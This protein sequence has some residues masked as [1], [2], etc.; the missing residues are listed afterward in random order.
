M[1]CF[2]P[3]SK[4][5]NTFTISGEELKHLKV[6]RIKPG[7]KVG[8]IWEGRIFECVV[9]HIDKNK[10]LLSFSREPPPQETKTRVHLFVCVPQSVGNF[11]E[12]V[13]LATEC[14]AVS[15]TPVLSSRSFTKK[16]VLKKKTPRWE[17]IVKEAMKQS[18]RAYYLKL[19]DPLEIQE[20]RP[21]GEVGYLFTPQG[22]FI[23][24]PKSMKFKEVSAL[25]GPEGGFSEEERSMLKERG[26]Q[27]VALP[28]PILR[29]E[30]ATAVITSL[31]LSLGSQ[32]KD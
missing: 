25:I 16:E 32:N 3:S 7:E 26:F 22:E 20:V 12:V 4:E 5:R 17:R 13:R 6:R 1:Y 21:L 18:N 27:E 15:L 28:T 29:V 11:D 8:I 24:C 19:N 30:T 10:A 31:L 23:R 2:F 14:G 9:E